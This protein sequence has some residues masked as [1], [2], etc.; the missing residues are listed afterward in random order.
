MKAEDQAKRL[1]DDG[2]RIVVSLGGGKKL[3]QVSRDELVRLTRPGT[4]LKF[5]WLFL[6]ADPTKRP[7]DAIRLDLTKWMRRIIEGCGATIKDV[8]TGLYTTNLQHRKAIVAVA[9]DMITRHRQGKQ[10]AANSEARRGR[11]LVYFSDAQKKEAK[12]IWRNTKDFPK[13]EDVQR[14]YDALIPGFTIHRAFKAWKG[15]K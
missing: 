13:W 9:D 1:E 11:P 7:A 5:V 4:V 8:D 14:E 6:L 3:K 10:S 2:A 15:R 12:A